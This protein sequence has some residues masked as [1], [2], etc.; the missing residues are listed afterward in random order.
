MDN[1]RHYL[2]ELMKKRYLAAI[3]PTYEAEVLAMTQDELREE[4][5]NERFRELAFEGH[6]WF[7]L[8]RTTRQELTKT[9]KG[10]TYVL[11]KDDSRYTL[12]IPSEAIAANPGLEEENR[13]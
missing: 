10:E 7:D 8:R 3:Y 2:T 11:Q 4:I 9:Y 12:R 13:E 5:Y 6:R 1:A